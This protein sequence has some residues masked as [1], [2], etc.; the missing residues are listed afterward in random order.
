M[1]HQ[2]RILA[3]LAVLVIIIA[4]CGRA[5]PA[6]TPGPGTP[7]APTPAAGTPAPGTPGAET[8]GAATPAPATPTVT[9]PGT[10]PEY[11]QGVTDDSIKIG[12]VAP[13]TG[14]GAAF[15]KAQ[16]MVEALY[17]EVNANGG[18]HGRQLELVIEDDQCD[19][20]TAQLG[21]TK[22]IESDQV[23]MIHGGICSNALIA[24]LPAIED[25]GIP[26]LVN[27]ASTGATTNPPLRN[28]FH[29][30]LT[31]PAIAESIGPFVREAAAALGNRVGIVAHRDEWGIGW[32]EALEASLEGSDVEIVAEEEITLEAGDATPQV[33]RLVRADPD[34]VV[35]FAFPQPFSVLL[36][37]AHAQGLRVP[38]ITGNTVQPD[39]QLDRVGNREAVEPLLSAYAYK[40]PVSAPEYSQYRELLEE[41]Y[42]QDEWDSNAL[43]AITGA[44][45]NI[46]ALQ[47][48][49]D[50][51]TWDNWIA[52]MEQIQGFETDVNVSPVTFAPYDP[53]DPS[54]RRGGTEVAFAY[55]DPDASD[56][57]LLV[58]QRWGDW[59]GRLD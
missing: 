42:P 6:D 58:V 27:S 56:A 49:G 39:E 31:Q 57:E 54:S 8:P 29:P 3:V 15:G 50:Q 19:P 30:G 48:M 55:L 53:D 34:F 7:Q 51:V 23:F 21:I 35:A 10:E 22:L 16:H 46:E 9:A 11:S 36:R 28:L 12:L 41:Y 26:F 4:A 59:R 32:L 43:L 33:Q 45:V 5:G 17:R 47:R 14:P 1:R 40:Y 20:T 18:I 25:S 44:L 38:I 52:T 37:D 2:P 24:A 13:L